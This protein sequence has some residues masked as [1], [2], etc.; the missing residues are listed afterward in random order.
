M[1]WRPKS[2]A[3]L[4]GARGLLAGFV[5][6]VRCDDRGEPI[7]PQLAV[8]RRQPRGIDDIAYSHLANRVQQPA[9]VAALPLDVL[10]EAR[11]VGWR[12]ERLVA[13]RLGS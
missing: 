12:P 11:V 7:D 5:V 1:A 4:A 10:S 8:A 6:R 13:L 3:E 2:S 9:A